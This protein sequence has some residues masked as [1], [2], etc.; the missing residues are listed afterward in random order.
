ML[1]RAWRRGGF[2]HQEGRASRGGGLPGDKDWAADW[3]TT[4]HRG[5]TE[6][7]S[8]IL[9]EGFESSLATLPEPGWSATVD[10]RSG[11][12]FSYCNLKDGSLKSSMDSSRLQWYSWFLAN[13]LRAAV[14]CFQ[15]KKEKT[16]SSLSRTWHKKSPGIVGIL[17][18]YLPKLT[19]HERTLAT[20]PSDDILRLGSLV[21]DRTLKH[22]S[23]IS[24]NE[25]AMDTHPINPVWGTS[26]RG[27]SVQPEWHTELWFFT[28]K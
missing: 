8:H 25:C 20:G 2:P 17:G 16:C 14:L 24:K 5:H 7:A 6:A 21:S 19:G 27:T 22:N 28:Y 1:Q 13:I 3:P 23:L 18:T 11:P 26:P 12:K 4:Q 15:W 9:I 10:R